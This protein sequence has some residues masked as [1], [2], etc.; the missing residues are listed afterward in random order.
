VA[1]YSYRVQLN[2]DSWFRITKNN[3]QSDT[4]TLRGFRN[5]DAKE[6]KVKLMLIADMLKY[7]KHWKLL[8]VAR[9]KVSKLGLGA[10]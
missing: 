9:F 1:Y 6:G 3:K 4:L 10:T 7:L 2:S 5:F 8:F